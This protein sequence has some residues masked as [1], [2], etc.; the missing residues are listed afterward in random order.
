MAC[1]LINK[2]K[3]KGTSASSWADHK[4]QISKADSEWNLRS[5]LKTRARTVAVHISPRDS[6]DTDTRAPSPEVDAKYEFLKVDVY[7]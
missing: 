2:P 4:G 6:E 7:Y 3:G 5:S 1:I